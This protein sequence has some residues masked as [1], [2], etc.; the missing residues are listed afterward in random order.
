MRKIFQSCPDS[1]FNL[2]LGFFPFCSLGN[3]NLFAWLAITNLIKIPLSN[4]KNDWD[5]PKAELNICVSQINTWEKFFQNFFL[6]AEILSYVDSKDELY[7]L[8]KIHNRKIWQNNVNFDPLYWFQKC[9]I[10]IEPCIYWKGMKT[11]VSALANSPYFDIRQFFF[12]IC[13]TTQW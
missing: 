7:I 2:S 13:L 5:T 9:F 1:D 10:F 8:S 11:R 12:I 3:A 4:V 6:K